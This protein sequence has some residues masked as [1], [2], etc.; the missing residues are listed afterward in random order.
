MP[1]QNV[2]GSAKPS[3]LDDSLKS[4][5]IGAAA[6]QIDELTAAKQTIA[7]EDIPPDLAIKSFERAADAIKNGIRVFISY[8]FIHQELAEKFRDLIREYGQSRLAKDRD[9]QPV[10][11]I[12][13]QGVE[14]G[15]EYRKQIH[16]EIGKAHWFF[17]LLPDAQFDREWPIYEAGYFQRGMTASERLICVHH[18][19]VAK[20]SQFQDLQAYESSPEGLQRLFTE[21][22]FQKQAISGMNQITYEDYKEHLQK[23]TEDLSKLFRGERPAVAD[24]CGR[25]IEIEH[26]DGRYYDKEADLLS[27]K[28][29]DMKNLRE[30]FDRPDTF[31]GKFGELI[32]DVNDNAHGR[33]WIDALSGAL[34]DVVTNHIPRAVEVPFFGS[35]RGWS[36]R[37]NLHCVWRNAEN[38]Q[39]EHF[40]VIFTEE[41]GERVVNVPETLEALETALRLAYR[42]WWEIYGA[43]DRRLTA[44]D[45]E[46]IYRYTQRAEQEAQS[47]GAM[48]MEVL[49]RAFKDPEQ[50]LLRD[51]FARYFT[52]YRNPQTNNGRIDRAFRDRDP[53]LMKD[54]LD[55]LKP[56][57]LWFLKAATKRFAELVADIRGGEEAA[58]PKA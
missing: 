8:K 50:K 11:F 3:D 13:K 6:F 43:Y 42:S 53:K 44:Q 18:K 28:I 37:P 30:A 9:G 21:L 10:V 32:A 46:D 38:G 26:E 23:D 34:H 17:L 45:V 58:V 19:S 55:E 20:A 57:S 36:F 16:E 25:Y 39:I 52:E 22:F 5:L 56:N 29:L 1:Q 47:R 12:A 48:D 4:A 33:Q 49:V 27:A 2:F 51:Q 31:Q 54:C 7:A 41:I 40:Q 35:K 14:A 24:V 15:K